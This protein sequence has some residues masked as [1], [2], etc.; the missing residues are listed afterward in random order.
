MIRESA[1]PSAMH[2]HAVQ[3]PTLIA[4]MGEAGA[5]KSTLI[6]SLLQ[7][8]A[9][10][11]GVSDFSRPIVSQSENS[12]PTS[13]GVH[14][15]ADP[16]TCSNHRPLLYADC[17]GLNSQSFLPMAHYCKMHDIPY[18]FTPA[19]GSVPEMEEKIG[20]RALES[21]NMLKVPTCVT[22]DTIKAT[23]FKEVDRVY[24][25]LMYETADI[26][27]YVTPRVLRAACFSLMLLY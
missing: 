27:V 7:L 15:Y 10:L 24:P 25:M 16:V 13:N 12:W 1:Q 8:G 26:V 5:G 23:E 17:Q 19:Q 6:G 9:T 3:H 11:A 18:A 4:F 14:L 21:F 20:T 2:R 22:S